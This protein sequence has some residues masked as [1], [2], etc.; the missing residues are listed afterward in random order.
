MIVAMAAA[1]SCTI[2]PV[3]PDPALEGKIGTMSIDLPDEL[4]K[5]MER[6]FFKV[7]A[8]PLS[9]MKFADEGVQLREW[10]I[11]GNDLKVGEVGKIARVQISSQPFTP[12]S[13]RVGEVIHEGEDIY[14]FSEKFK[15]NCMLKAASPSREGASK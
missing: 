15:G 12:F 3:E 14:R 7:S 10:I 13:I 9:T 2:F 1:L 4:S 5:E 6:A 11:R 8:I